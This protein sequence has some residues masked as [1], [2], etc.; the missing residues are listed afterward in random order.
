MGID[1]EKEPRG[2]VQIFDGGTKK[3]RARYAPN[4]IEIA[5]LR[6][7]LFFADLVERKEK[8]NTLRP[9]LMSIINAT[10]PLQEHLDVPFD[11][12]RAEHKLA[13]L[14]PDPLYIFYVNIVS[15]KKVYGKVL[16]FF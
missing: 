8:L 12:L 4:D 7:I 1:S 10:K 13:F 2:T 3:I 14:L 6:H 5:W 9:L 15:Y 11:Q 16:Q